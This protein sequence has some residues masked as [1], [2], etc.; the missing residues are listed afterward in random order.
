M[1]AR[2]E[3]SKLGNHIIFVSFSYSV[4][5]KC[6]LSNDFHSHCLTHLTPLAVLSL[7]YSVWHHPHHTITTIIV[8]IRCQLKL[9]RIEAQT[10]ELPTVKL[11]RI[12]YC[13]IDVHLWA[14]IMQ[15]PFFGFIMWTV[16]KERE[17]VCVSNNNKNRRANISRCVCECVCVWYYVMNSDWDVIWIWCENTR[18]LN[19]VHTMRVLLLDFSG[20][21]S[22]HINIE[23]A[24]CDSTACC[25]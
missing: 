9:E 17:C 10:N 20:A 24:W 3:G 7:A 14:H 5:D 4:V 16:W 12:Q 8:I 1:K 6:Q 2:K 18:I 19:D 13:S 22:V 25:S 23:N 11:Q 21:A 15:F